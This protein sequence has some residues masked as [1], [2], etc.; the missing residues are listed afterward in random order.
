MRRPEANLR[1]WDAGQGGGAPRDIVRAVHEQRINIHHDEFLLAIGER[2]SRGVHPGRIDPGRF[3]VRL[4]SPVEMCDSNW[5]RNIRPRHAGQQP[6]RRG[7]LGTLL[8]H[9]G[10]QTDGKQQYDDG[11][12]ARS[13]PTRM[14]RTSITLVW[15]GPV[16]SK[17]PSGSKK[18]YESLLAK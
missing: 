8:H 9:V 4:G 10:A 18:W 17:S 15:V 7:I 12:H 2:Q 5:R 11:L 1:R 16:I 3:P 14:S 13:F 6:R